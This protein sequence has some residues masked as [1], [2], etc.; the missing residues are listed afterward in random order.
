MKLLNLKP[1]IFILLFHVLVSCIESNNG[2]TKLIP[3]NDSLLPAHE[4]GE[5]Q[6]I[7]SLSISLDKMSIDLVIS[8]Y[9]SKRLTIMEEKY[10]KRGVQTKVDDL[11]N[12]Y[13]S[14]SKQNPV[15]FIFDFDKSLNQIILKYLIGADTL[16][17]TSNLI[18]EDIVMFKYNQKALLVFDLRNKKILAFC[19]EPILGGYDL[20]PEKLL[21]IQIL[22]VDLFP[23]AILINNYPLGQ[24]SSFILKRLIYSNDK[25][26]L[27]YCQD[28][29]TH[30]LKGKMLSE[31]YLADI[32]NC[33][34]H[35]MKDTT[36]ERKQVFEEI[37]HEKYPLWTKPIY[38]YVDGWK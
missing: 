22:N 32:I 37:K 16:I 34:N 29:E 3:A 7:S 15:R 20:S 9:V 21:A 24:N 4:R 36:G 35:S 12:N 28:I 30:F 6:A 8:S 19:F 13:S 26:S 11:I 25:S 23:D 5:A 38:C 33:F 10:L 2:T 1:F 27:Q 18:T 31:F 17:L 14:S